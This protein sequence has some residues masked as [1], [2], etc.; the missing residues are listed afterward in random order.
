MRAAFAKKDIRY[1]EAQAGI[2]LAGLYLEQGRTAD[3]KRLALQME[4]VFRTKGVHAEAR[5]A[6][7]LFRRAVELETVTVEL[8]RRLAAYLRQAQDDPE[9]GFEGTL[10]KP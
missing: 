9:L 1:D 4:P 5:K 3:V 2:E 6:L 8:V 10:Q 7:L